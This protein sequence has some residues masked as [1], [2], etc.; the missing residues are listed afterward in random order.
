MRE[1]I[2]GRL[3][4]GNSAD[5]GNVAA[6]MQ[7]GISAII[8]LAAEQIMPTLPRSLVYCRFPILDGQQTSQAVLRAAIE[9]IVSLLSKE[10]PILVCCSAGMSRSPA[11]VA[12]ALSVLQ[13]G[14]PDD[15]LRQV[16]LGHPHDVSPQLWQDVRD[17]CA[18][19][20]ERKQP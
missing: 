10:I 17:V 5:A 19:M 16:A 11:V 1:I 2:P 7:A 3:W 6:V 8:D 15:R 14:S 9:T 13:G 20:A 4:L 12:G 18:E